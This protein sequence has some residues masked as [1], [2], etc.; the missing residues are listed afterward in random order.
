MEQ[1][2]ATS[3]PRSGCF[4]PVPATPPPWG[5]SGSGGLTSTGEIERARV[6]IEDLHG[7]RASFSQS[8]HVVEEAEGERVWGGDVYVFA[9]EG[10]PSAEKAYAWSAPLPGSEKRRFYAMLHEGPVDSPEK[11]VRAAIVQAL[12]A[13]K[14]TVEDRESHPVQS[15]K[16]RLLYRWACSWFCAW[17]W[18]RV[19]VCG[20]Q[21]TWPPANPGVR[22]RTRHAYHESGNN[23][24]C[25]RCVSE[26][27]AC[28]PIVPKVSRHHPVN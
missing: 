16:G 24:R 26:L 21:P 27:L 19:I 2:L 28:R 14:L 15:P 5:C 25:C 17:S 12:R 11:A 13:R 7:G 4:A 18:A 8:V 23:L 22:R 6:A 3:P 20:G 1:H 9:L 10:H